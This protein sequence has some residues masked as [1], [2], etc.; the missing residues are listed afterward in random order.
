M[1]FTH[2][3][4]NEKGFTIVEVLIALTIFS[5]AIV[6]VITV[7]AQ[8]GASLT[9]AKNKVTA[10]YLASE[11]LE[12]VRGLR[13]TAVL[14]DPGHESASFGTFVTTVT[15][16]CSSSPCDVNATN[17]T[18]AV[19]PAISDLQVCTA[20]SCQLYY[21]PTTGYY[22]DQPGIPGETPTL[23]TRAITFH[24]ISAH[25]L[26]V[27]STVNWH[28]GTLLSTSVVTEDLFD[29]YQST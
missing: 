7:A 1:S 17:V 13:D 9:K 5:I 20:G 21:D 23:F 26:Q 12:L 8:G 24:S 14:A 15:G 11:G 25:E 2:T 10:D 16:D 3:Q 22:T 18:L 27:T 4:T 19:F 6:G 28:E 29:W